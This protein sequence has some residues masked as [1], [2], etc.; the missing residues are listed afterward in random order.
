MK[1][2]PCSSRLASSYIRS[3][4]DF[5]NAMEGLGFVS[6]SVF[7]TGS[8]PGSPVSVI[9]VGKCTELHNSL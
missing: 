8:I 1:K 2:F 7:G 6:G 3:I 4:K 9:N 5:A